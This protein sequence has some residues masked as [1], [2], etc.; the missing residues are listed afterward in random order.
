[1]IYKLMNEMDGLSHL[2]PDEPNSDLRGTINIEY[3]RNNAESVT[4]LYTY[5]FGNRALNIGDKHCL[6]PLYVNNEKIGKTK[7]F[8][9][10]ELN[11]R[12]SSFLKELIKKQ[13]VKDLLKYF[14][15][16][17]HDG[18]ASLMKYSLDINSGITPD[19]FVSVLEA[20]DFNVPTHLFKSNKKG[21][22]S[23]CDSKNK[24]V[25]RI[26]PSD[27][28]LAITDDKGELS[29]FLTRCQLVHSND[30]Y[31][32]TP[33]TNHRQQYAHTCFCEIDELREAWND[34]VRR[35]QEGV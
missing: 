19:D 35:L 31:L 23:C 26:L 1:M 28:L 3:G 25:I 29:A 6:V 7:M 16:A 34:Y 24:S 18:F 11:P 15:K 33:P 27:Q 14:E 8:L 32:Y 4:I 30:P 21:C 22:L 20:C 17:G 12:I 2:M 9:K 5:L 13:V 10:G